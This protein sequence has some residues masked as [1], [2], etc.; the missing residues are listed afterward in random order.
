MGKNS[1][2][3]NL[4]IEL[5][6]PTVVRPGQNWQVQNKFHFAQK[7]NKLKILINK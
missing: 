3:Q 2:A 5:K 7:K 1:L 4:F 6:H